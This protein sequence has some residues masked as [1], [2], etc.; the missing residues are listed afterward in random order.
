LAG[1]VTNVRAADRPRS[2]A[3][4]PLVARAGAR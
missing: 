4:A 3:I 1:G 2:V